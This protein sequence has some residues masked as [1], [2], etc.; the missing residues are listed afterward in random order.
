MFKGI[1]KIRVGWVLE[2][3]KLYIQMFPPSK[4]D[5]N[6]NTIESYSPYELRQLLQQVL[7]VSDWAQDRE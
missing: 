4:D 7:T 6:V 2:A 1:L 5:T 3:I